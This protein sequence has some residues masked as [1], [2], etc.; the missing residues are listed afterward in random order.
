A[1]TASA[2]ESPQT[3][4]AS[5]E[6]NNQPAVAQTSVSASPAIGVVPAKAA[7]SSMAASGRMWVVGGLLLAAL[8][9]LAWVIV[10][11]F[12]R[13]YTFNVPNYPRAPSSAAPAL[14]KPGAASP[15]K[16]TLQGNSFVGGPR[17]VSLQLKSTKPA[18]RHS[19]IP[20]GDLSG[21]FD[22]IKGLGAQPSRG[23]AVQMEE[24]NRDVSFIGSEAESAVG[25]VI[26]QTA[27]NGE[28]LHT[29]TPQTAEMAEVSAIS[30]LTEVTAMAP[31]ASPEIPETVEEI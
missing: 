2:A 22:L 13:R 29:D 8:L 1:R 4:P 27:E 28:T 3:A 6:Q 10:P 11:T 24:P 14:F 26:E 21:G 25:P 31:Q 5:K 7:P 16:N 18:L 9:I 20:S 12:R 19:A 17:Q 23:S 15:Q 30:E